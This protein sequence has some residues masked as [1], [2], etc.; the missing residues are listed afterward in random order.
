[1]NVD[2]FN[3]SCKESARKDSLFGICDDQIG[4]KAYT[5]ISDVNK[6]IAKVKNNNC[7]EVTFTAIDNCIEILKEG[8]KD[9]ES[10]CDGMLTFGKSIYLVE[11]KKRRTG[12]WFKEAKE[13]LEN[14]IKLL[15]KNHDIDEF[16][17]KKAYACNKKH[18]NFTIINNELG[19]RFFQ[20]TSFRIDAQTEIVIK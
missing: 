11:L 6:W 14:T 10:S 7:I 15:N 2:F 17:Y 4:R 18:P 5:D 3:T 12:G 1:M 13:Q 19:K 8:T 9:K 16:K 20:E